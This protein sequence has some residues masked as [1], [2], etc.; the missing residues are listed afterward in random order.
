MDRNS[1]FTVTADTMSK[2]LPNMAMSTR[3]I[4][5]D[6]FASSH[7]GIAPAMH[8]AVN[9]RYARDPT[10]LVP[11]ENKNPSDP[12]DSFVYSR[13]SAPNGARFEKVLE[14]L[15]GGP[16]IT[17]STGLA[18]FHAIMVLLN[19]KRVFIGDGYHG[20]HAVIHLMAKLTGVQKLGLDQL[21]QVEPGDLIHIET[22]VNPTGEARNIAFFSHV[23]R[24][25]GAYLTVDSTFGPP[26]LQNPL[27]FG[28]DIVLHSAT[29]YIGGHSDMMGG[30]LVVRPANAIEKWWM[31]TLYA[32]RL[33]MGN[34]IGNLEGW[35]GLRSLRTLELRVTRQSQ[36]AENLAKWIH[37]EIN[38]SSSDVGRVVESIKH[39][40]LQK[41]GVKE[42]WLNKQMPRGFAPVF[43]IWM[44][45]ADQA[46]QFPSKLCIFQHAT[47]LGDV[48]S[49]IEWRAMS[50]TTCDPR[51]LR[52][53]C[54]LED[55]NDLRKDL[56]QG[57]KA[58]L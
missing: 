53:S 26:P 3:A 58:L 31:A 18:A 27:E 11:G 45:T 51:L 52:I 33:V 15:L 19:P 13:Y 17:Y 14:G 41:N 30:V 57:F 12:N 24:K 54:G 8:V 50:D 16:V 25:A 44:K 6:D 43:A 48:E 40:S 10:K 49:L 4:H 29:K 22:P 34:S 37:E 42:A 55:V 9:Y 2:A 35:L 28:A 21:G 56:L 32:E 7:T 38:D 47:S 46:R 36:T 1:T 23:A 39:A 20:V 5:G